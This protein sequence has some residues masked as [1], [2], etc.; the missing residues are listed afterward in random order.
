M[1]RFAGEAA[2]LVV[3]VLFGVAALAGDSSAGGEGAL[4]RAASLD[5]VGL[6]SEAR[7]LLR[8]E[9]ESGNRSAR[10]PLLGS[11]ARGGEFHEA[12][13]F[14][15]SWGGADSLGMPDAHFGEGMLLEKSGEFALAASAYV[16]SLESEPL[17]ADYAAVRAA[18]SLEKAD[19]AKEAIALDELGGET[20]RNQDLAARARWRAA[21]LSLAAL[22]AARALANLGAIPDR[23][24]IARR[25][26][27]ELEASA[28]RSL[29]DEAGERDALRRLVDAAPSANAAVRAVDRLQL[30]G[31]TSIA[32]RLAFA[33]VGLAS[34]T[35]TLAEREARAALDSLA[36]APDAGSEGRARLLLGRAFSARNKFTAARDELAG[37]PSEAAPEDRAEAALERAR[38]LWKSD[39]LDA[40]LAEYDSLATSTAPEA[41][42]AKASWEAARE[43]KDARRWKDAAER[44]GRFQSAFPANEF[45]DDALWHRVRALLEIGELDAALAADSTLAASSPDSPFR[46]E[47]SYWVTNALAAI[48]RS[49]DACA[50]ARTLVRDRPDGYWTLRA[51]ARFEGEI[52]GPFAAAMSMR[53]DS[54]F[55]AS[56]DSSGSR[57]ILE[58]EPFRRAEALARWGLLDEA[59]SELSIV[60]R[61]LHDDSPGLLALAR[62]SAKIG[63]TRGGMQSIAALRSRIPG[64]ILDG[65]FPEEAARLLYPIAHLDEVLRW[66]QEYSVDPN[67]VFGVMREESWFDAEA[68]SPA[69]AIGLLQIMPP[70]GHDLARQVGLKKFRRED[71]FDPAINV[72]LGV[73]Y[74]SRLVL[75][76]DGEAVLALAAYNAGE[77]NARRWKIE[78]GGK[79]DVDRTVAGI[80]Y[81]ETSEYV[82]RVSTTREI[83]RTLYRDALSRLHVESL[84]ASRVE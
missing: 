65:S 38:C 54:S 69:G 43:A 79:V 76:H 22:D 45:A 33:E 77:R 64:S 12:R 29:G 84:G 62:E 81:K 78:E 24:P 8:R 9:V 39:L 37:L 44:L 47:S 35:P 7:A 41:S 32:D 14:L 27:L 23:S 10:A 66:S 49:S 13:K 17:L 52:C 20:A 16:R 21:Q 59:E 2:R 61:L 19:R 55:A 26:R 4:D 31:A 40:A 74:L 6:A 60:R 34:R 5:S 11:L 80:T 56:A 67:L 36:I 15:E 72:R 68:V 50:L 42:R 3:A 82:Q 30:L 25:D 63:V 51:R 70:T 28:K 75:R 46:D 48:G 73:F 58:S 71:L 57:T 83:Y 1:T 53:A 18:A